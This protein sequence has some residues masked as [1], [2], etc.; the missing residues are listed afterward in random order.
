MKTFAHK[1]DHSMTGRIKNKMRKQNKMNN[2][3]RGKKNH[4]IIKMKAG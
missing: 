3:K 4:G 2:N 1:S